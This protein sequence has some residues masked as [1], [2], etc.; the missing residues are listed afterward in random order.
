MKTEGQVTIHHKNCLNSS[1]CLSVEMASRA[2]STGRSSYGSSASSSRGNQS[3]APPGGE[4]THH[5]DGSVFTLDRRYSDLKLIG[6]GSYG[7]VCKAKDSMR[8]HA[9]SSASSSS[10]YNVAIKKIHPM[11]KTAADAKHVLREIRI[12]RCLGECTTMVIYT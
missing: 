7:V 5:I 4:R 6:K 11:A 1:N 2:S 12:M 9:S 8:G 3:G 10:T